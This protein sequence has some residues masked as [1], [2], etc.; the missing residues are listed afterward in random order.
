MPTLSGRWG[1]RT[2]QPR[3]RGD[4][5]ATSVLS[6]FG[7]LPFGVEPPGIEPGLPACHAGVVPLDHDPVLLSG[8]PGSRTPI[9][10]L[11]ARRLSIGPAA[12]N[13]LSKV[14]PGIE[15]GLPPYHSGVPPKHL[16]TLLA[17]AQV[18]PD[19]VEPSSPACH[20]GVVA[21]GP[22]SQLSVTEV[23]VE[24]TKSRGLSG[25]R[26]EGLVR[27]FACLRTRSCCQIAG[28]GVAPGCRGL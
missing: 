16:Q 21:V 7:Y 25:H 4:W 13:F 22:R 11:Q 28:P 10:W 20:A 27:R 12:R 5:L 9:T 1:N 2:R 8:P 19:G 17:S 15:P 18:T 14:R 26:P 24:L 3:F 6:H 23:R